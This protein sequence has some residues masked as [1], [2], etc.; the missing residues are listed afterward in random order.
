M[1]EAAEVEEV[2]EVEE[3]TEIPEAA[4]AEPP[5]L[6]EDVLECVLEEPP[7]AARDEAPE[8]EPG[9]ESPANHAEGRPSTSAVHGP[10]YHFYQ[11]M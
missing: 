4:T 6:P 2:P 8:P 1:E 5:G 9:D 7:E 3:A 11:G 10:Y